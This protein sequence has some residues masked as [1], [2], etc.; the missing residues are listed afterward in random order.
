MPV[1]DAGEAITPASHGRP[2]RWIR[3]VCGVFVGSLCVRAWVF[4]QGLHE[5]LE[6][7]GPALPVRASGVVGDGH[8]ELLPEWLPVA[9]QRV[10]GDRGRER[11]H[12]AL[13]GRV[14]G[15]FTAAAGQVQ[16]DRLSGVL[17]SPPAFHRVRRPVPLSPAIQ[18]KRQR[19]RAAHL[20]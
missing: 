11:E 12:G 7:G 19:R 20:R 4:G 1:R 15:E 10:L 13:P 3:H 6:R 16:P 8:D 9:A 14:E 17:I 5:C 2:D 18:K